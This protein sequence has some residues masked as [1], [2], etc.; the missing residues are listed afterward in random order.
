MPRTARLIALLMLLAI[1]SRPG[2]I[3]A[4]IKKDTWWET[5]RA[6]RPSIAAEAAAAPKEDAARIWQDFWR[7]LAKDFPD[8]TAAG[9]SD[10]LETVTRF[11]R[12][13]RPREFHVTADGDAGGDGTSARPFSTLSQA[14][15]AIRALKGAGPLRQPIDIVVHGGTYDFDEPLRLGPQDSGTAACPIT[16]RSN[17]DDPAILSAGKRISGNWR[18]EH[19]G[20]WH[21]DLEDASAKAAS[22]WR[23]RQL[24]VNGE[25]ATL[26]RYPNLDPSDICRKG[27]LHARGEPEEHILAGVGTPGD[28]IEYRFEIH[29]GG[30]YAIWTGVATILQNVE[31]LLRL[32]ID[33][34]DVPLRPMAGSGD[35]RKVRFSKAVEVPLS[36]SRHT[37]RWLRPKPAP[38]QPGRET[39]VHFDS[40]CLSDNTAAT[41]Q[42]DGSLPTTTA[43]ETRL[44]IEAE[45][46][47]LRIGGSSHAGFQIIKLADARR[48]TTGK[49]IVCEPGTIK[50]AWAEAPHA[51]VFMFPAWGWFNTITWLDGADIRKTARTAAGKTYLSDVIRIRGR[52]AATPI[53]PGNRFYIFNLRS[54]L[55]APGEWHLDYTSGGLHYMPPTAKSPEGSE[56]IAPR[57]DRLVEIASPSES[58]GRVE[59]VSF[60]GFVFKHTDY[61]PDQP[62]TRSSEDCAVLLENAWHC[63][64]EDCSFENIG[65]YAVRLSLDSC[66]NQIR[67]N[68]VRSAG[69]GGII[70]RGPWVGWG[71]NI[72]APGRAAATLYPMGNLISDNHIRHCGAIKKYVAGIHADTRPES[73]AHAPGNVVSRNLIH[74]MPRNGIFSFRNHGGYVYESNHIHD[75]LQE[76]DDGGL[77]HICTAALNGTA[78]AI[79]RNNLLHDVAAYRWD[80]EWFGRRD[81][82]ARSN[83]HGVYLDGNTSGVLVESNI[84]ANTRRGGVFLHGG[85]NNTVRNNI[86]LNDRRNQFWMTDTWRGNRLE[87]N[88]VMWTNATP[89]YAAIPIQSLE[90]A[91]P[92]LFNSNLIW[93]ASAD[94][95]IEGQGVFKTWRARGFDRH[96]LVADPRFEAIDLPN[97]IC[98]LAPNSP[99]GSIGFRPIDLSGLKTV[100]AAPD[101][102]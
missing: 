21:I 79:I 63:V 42:E 67:G 85:E 4:Y 59:H 3:A 48:R 82:D 28:W 8:A 9:L 62:D 6:S 60:R 52:E 66:M 83:G 39:R 44:V 78:P 56:I 12:S 70:L 96:S 84:I 93:H 75:V 10:S 29:R 64:I 71:R 30:T 101:D 43:D 73:L 5:V 36:A 88:I 54:E 87:K 33:G 58:E 41:P 24:F 81:L 15:D 61:T 99:A 2:A 80:D 69:A 57:I 47:A 92:A 38:G 94:V 97:R 14:R 22:P 18:R 46:A 16:Y 74:H 35:W 100:T 68:S 95:E 34:K 86:I 91:D 90:G 11:P 26:A 1:E 102:Q 27:W 50:P 32:E 7:W 51:E 53:W 23:F 31:R 98:G 13:A 77:I 76:S 40:F 49:A 65:G 45:D 17:S 72:L 37:M 20:I 19:N 25:R 89:L 55:D